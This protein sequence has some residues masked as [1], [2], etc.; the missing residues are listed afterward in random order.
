M[1]LSEK[2][3]IVTGGAGGLGRAICKTFAGGG[4]TVAIVVHS[5][6][7]GGLQLSA[8]IEKKWGKKPLL[9]KADVSDSRQVREMVDTVYHQ[10]GR[11]DILVN[12]AGV[13][14]LE[15]V[16]T[17]S[18]EE[19]DRVIE[20]NLKGCFL[21]AKSV[22]PYMKRQNN[23]KII[24]IGSMTAKNGG[25]ISGAV[26][27]ASKGAVHSLTFALAKELTPYHITVNAVAPGPVQTEMLQKAN[28]PAEQITNWKNSIPLKR[29]AQAEDVAKAVLFLASADANYITGEIIDIN[30]GAHTD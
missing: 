29:F 18:E 15:R 25:T 14:I 8:E 13:L 19:W 17:I 16:E 3:A 23:G 1:R 28:I 21:C 7:E 6:L 30:G 26:Y 22:I 12:N 24:N 27:S 10:W 2:I 9:L 5:N 4:A 11:I 20:V